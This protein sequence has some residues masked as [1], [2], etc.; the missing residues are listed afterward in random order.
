MA[1]P[2]ILPLAATPPSLASAKAGVWLPG[3]VIPLMQNAFQMDYRTDITL[4]SAQILALFTTAVTL[5]PAPG[6][7]LMICPETIIIRLLGGTAY[8]DGGGGAVSFNVGTMT[9]ALAANTIFTG[10]TAGQRSQ[11]IVAFA[12]TSTAA[13]PPTNENAALTINKATGNFAAGTGTCHITVFYT[14]ESAT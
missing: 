7:G 2:A 8:T 6:A 12:G 9:T 14:V 10:P 4:T 5:V 13:N 1:T 3:E 11:Q